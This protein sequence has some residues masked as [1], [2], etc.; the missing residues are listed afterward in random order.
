[1]I[2]PIS[3]ANPIGSITFG[4]FPA[5]AVP[6]RGFQS[7]V[8]FFKQSLIGHIV[9]SNKYKDWFVQRAY[10]IFWNFSSSR[11]AFKLQ[12][13]GLQQSEYILLCFQVGVFFSKVYEYGKA[14]SFLWY[15]VVVEVWDFL[16]NFL[17]FCLYNFWV[18]DRVTVWAKPMVNWCEIDSLAVS[19]KVCL[20]SIFR[21]ALRL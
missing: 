4:H 18:W 5:N 1:M 7:N 11:D 17:D 12:W 9:V 3:G 8:A 21:S 20:N 15:W 14:A 19:P 2:K 13:K 10:E 6:S 16:S